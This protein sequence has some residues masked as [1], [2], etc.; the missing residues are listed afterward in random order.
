MALNLHARAT[1]YCMEG[2]SPEWVV[3]ASANFG[4]GNP[5]LGPFTLQGAQVDAVG[6]ARCRFSP[7]WSNHRS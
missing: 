1:H 3:H 4:E 7:F 2:A 6:K 5:K